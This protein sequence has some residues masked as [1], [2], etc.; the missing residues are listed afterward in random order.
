M[1]LTTQVGALFGTPS[2]YRRDSQF[3]ATPELDIFNLS[4]S[5]AVIPRLAQSNVPMPFSLNEPSAS[6]EACPS[7]NWQA[8]WN[9]TCSNALNLVDAFSSAH[10]HSTWHDSG[11]PKLARKRRA[12]H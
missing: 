9:L 2:E 7:M 3:I 10:F 11:K 12:R 8:S 1:G 6:P 5:T 4:Y